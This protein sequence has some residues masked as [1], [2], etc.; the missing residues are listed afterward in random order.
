MKFILNIE[1]QV[2]ITVAFEYNSEGIP[3][4]QQKIKLYFQVDVTLSDET[5]RWIAATQ[6][7][8]N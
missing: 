2:P 6:V 7:L 5:A 8:S 4:N 3:K 1:F